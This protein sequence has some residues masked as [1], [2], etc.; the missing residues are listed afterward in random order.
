MTTVP[1]SHWTKKV[2]SLLDV[3]DPVWKAWRAMKEDQVKILP[4]ASNNKIVGVVSA[5]DI[6]RASDHNGGQSMSV[7]EAMS[8]DPLIVHH[9]NSLV[10]VAQ[11][12]IKKDQQHAIVTFDN[13]ESIGIFSWSEAVLFFLKHNNVGLAI[14]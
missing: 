1:V 2:N 14:S 12:M 5:K 6:V 7:K 10:E 13:D 3:S 11:S 4:V 8:L 9:N